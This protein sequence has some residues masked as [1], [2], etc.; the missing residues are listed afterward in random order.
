MGARR[1]AVLVLFTAAGI[2]AAWSDEPDGKSAF[3]DAKCGSC[4]SIESEGIS[5]TVK[6]ESMK[7]PDLD[8]IGDQR[9]A[10]WIASYLKREVKVDD[11]QH[12]S[13]WRGSDEALAAIASWLASLE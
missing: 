11:K 9:D 5:A 4:H 10:D 12:R 7:G 6:S 2:D 8:G 3:I 1:L 13:S